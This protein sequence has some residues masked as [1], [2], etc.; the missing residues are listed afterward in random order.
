MRED[1]YASSGRNKGH[2]KA[3]SWN[4]GLHPSGKRKNKDVKYITL[5]LFV[6][7][8]QIVIHNK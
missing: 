5:Q 1:L 6:D 4:R 3:L 8:N 7:N 2:I